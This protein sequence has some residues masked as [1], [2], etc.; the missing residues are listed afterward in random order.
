M[1]HGAH[2]GSLYGVFG[3]TTGGNLNRIGSLPA[4]DA[5]KFC[6]TLDRIVRDSFTQ[7]YWDITLPN[8]LDT[9]SA[10]SPPL[11]AYWAALNILDA[12]VLFSEQKVSDMLD[13]VV[14]P[15]K[16][17]E[18]HHL[19]PKAYLKSLDVTD[20][21]RVNAIANMA[22]VDWADNL[23]ISSKSPAE[24]WARMANF[25]DSQRLKR[26]IYWHA[27]PVGWE[28]LDY[29]EFCE[30]RR[31]LI[32]QVVREGFERLWETRAGSPLE[33]ASIQDVVDD[34]ESN[35][36]E[37][38]ER[39]RWS[40]GT[41]KKGKR[42][43]IIVKSV[44]G[45]MNSEGGS[46]LIGVSDNGTATG[47]EEDYATLSNGN[48]DGFGRFLTQLI[49]DKISGPSAALCRIS[50]HEADGKDVCRVDVAASAKPVFSCPA[51]SK[52]FTDFWVRQGNKT[53]Q[54]HG[55]EFLDYK[56]IHWG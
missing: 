49:G 15:V 50:F 34:G 45:F 41:D 13:P 27:L 51:N 31:K 25:V 21:S 32:A 52:E 19:F 17:I 53:E 1:V 48:R 23:A 38:K 11:A 24:Y 2:D 39:A 10:K 26:Q 16:D 3:N 12:E 35:I 36:L 5:D 55:N 37:F 47:L 42:E 56:E 40:H 43:Q 18:R 22:F 6:H 9:S 8:R 28:Q 14:T 29:D 54:L 46:L 44:A 30:R 4:K 33:Q 20:N 7:D